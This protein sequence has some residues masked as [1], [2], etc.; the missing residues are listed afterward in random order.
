MHRMTT[1][2]TV[3]RVSQLRVPHQVQNNEMIINLVTGNMEAAASKIKKR[4]TADKK[5]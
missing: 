3:T 1:G 4:N 5:M 2:C